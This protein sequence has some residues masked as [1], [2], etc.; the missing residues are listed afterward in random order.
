[1]YCE[2]NYV[3]RRMTHG[4]IIDSTICGVSLLGFGTFEFR[5][6]KVYS[7]DAQYIINLR[8]DYGSSWKGEMIFENV[9]RNCSTEP[10]RYNSAIDLYILSGTK[11][12]NHYFGYDCYAPGK[13][14]ISGTFNVELVGV[15]DG[16]LWDTE[17]TLGTIYVGKL[18]NGSTTS[19]CNGCKDTYGT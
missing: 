2:Y 14:T 12:T 6:I 13:V 1:M 15:R 19:A 7:N 4:A 3:N 17:A 11:T 16:T 9:Y 8:E 5:N 18:K 10:G